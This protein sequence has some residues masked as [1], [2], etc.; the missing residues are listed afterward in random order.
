M[1]TCNDRVYMCVFRNLA[2]MYSEMNWSR[3]IYLFF[4]NYINVV[5]EIINWCNILFQYITKKLFNLEKTTN[6]YIYIK[7]KIKISRII[8][9]VTLWFNSKKNQRIDFYYKY[10]KFLIFVINIRNFLF[11]DISSIIISYRYS[12][13]SRTPFLSHCE[14]LNKSLYKIY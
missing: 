6:L 3:I 14:L 2:I 13:C 10:K 7:R 8:Y 5:L 4:F 9:R 1:I 12:W 11:I